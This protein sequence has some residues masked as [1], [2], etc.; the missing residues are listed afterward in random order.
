VYFLCRATL[1]QR[2]N[3]CTLALAD[4]RKAVG[5][6]PNMRQVLEPV[7]RDCKK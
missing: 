7:F 3:N 6:N 4:A 2:T 1:Y 5:L